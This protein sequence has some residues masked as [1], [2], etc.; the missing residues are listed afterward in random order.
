MTR[1]LGTATALTLALAASGTSRLFADTK[2]T[3]APDLLA[4][5]WHLNEELSP[6]AAKRQQPSDTGGDP[7]RDG[8]RRGGRGGYGRPGGGGGFGGFGGGMGRR[9]GMGRG[10]GGFGGGGRAGMAEG[11]ED[12]NRMRVLMREMRQ[13]P[14]RL[15]LVVKDKQLSA[16]EDDGTVFSLPL[17]DKKTKVELGGEK[18]EARAKWDGSNIVTEWSAAKIKLTRTYESSP[19]GK[20]MTVRVIPQ[21]KK[22]SAP[23]G[24]SMM[25]VY[26]RD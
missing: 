23:V 7:T 18:L 4:G 25:L 3:G 8:G 6:D 1:R 13:A 11:A 10:G 22:G 2:N 20:V 21:E 17:T 12:R 19:D 5:A 14:K 9:G 15:A 24:P 16:T 26:D